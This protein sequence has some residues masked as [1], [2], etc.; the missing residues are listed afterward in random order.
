MF[1]SAEHDALLDVTWDTIIIGAGA[2]GLVA[3]VCLSK[4]GYRVLILESG[5]RH[6]AASAHLLNDCN[7]V[8]RFHSG[9]RDG[10]AR[11]VGGTTTLWGGQLTKFVAPDLRPREATGCR[12][13]PIEFSKIEKNYRRVADLLGLDL[14]YLDDKQLIAKAGISQAHSASHCTLFFTRWLQE[15]NLARYFA[16]EIESSKLM[17]IRPET[18]ANGLLFDARSRKIQAVTAVNHE[19]RSLTFSGHTVVLAAGTIEISRFLLLTAKTNPTVPWA[20]N[21]NVGRYFQD[22]LDL[23][24]G[25]INR[26]NQHGLQALFENRIINGHKYQP[27]VRF[28][29]EHIIAKGLLNVACSLKYE[30]AFAE[31]IDFLKIVVKSFRSGKSIANPLATILRVCSLARIWMPLAWHYLKNRRI[32]S[33]A[34]QGI[35]II[36]H[37][38]QTPESD[39][40][41]SLDSSKLDRFGDPIAKLNWK[42][43]ER[44]QIR[45]IQEFATCFR[46]YIKAVS[47]SM[48]EILPSVIDGDASLLD[49]ARDS[50]HQCG[51]ACMGKSSED[52]VVDAS[53]RPF[54]VDNMYVAGSAVFPSSSFANPTF[55]ALAL[56]L[57]IVDHICQRAKEK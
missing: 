45:A 17:C 8:G 32:L 3:G 57:D 42:I 24:I 27:K 40:R 37:C 53:S 5:S 19:G 35:R 33:L 14:E 49:R 51:G 43:D 47:G 2:V 18:H 38:E 1:L 12:Q 29:D 28:S 50:Y 4:R 20:S 39:S 9:I 44:A 52:G 11:I 16:E 7:S 10:R 25:G 48:V 31:D 54:G 46:D 6:H 30:S 21:Q 55:T 13:W 36:A 22:H 34:D 41:I 26:E 56:T 15:P 23:E